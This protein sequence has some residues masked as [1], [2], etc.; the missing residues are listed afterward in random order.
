MSHLQ[1][2]LDLLSIED[3]L[4]I[5]ES[6]YSAGAD[7]LEVGTPL[8]KNHGMLAV[9]R[10]KQS[11]PQATVVA[12]LKTADTGDLEVEIAAK[13]GAGV[14][15]V[16]AL[17]DD[18]TIKKAVSQARAHGVKIMAD[19]MEVKDKLSRAR[20][21]QDLG[22]D[23]LLLHTPIDLQK[24]KEEKVDSSLQEL[25][26]IK[27][28]VS[29]P[30]AAAGGVTPESARLLRKE[31]VEIFVVGSSITRARDIGKRVKEFSEVLGVERPAEEK[32]V[33]TWEEIVEGFE[34]LP[35]PFI[36]DAMRRFGAMRSLRPLLRGKRIAGRAFT[37]KTL[38]G[39]WGKVVKAIDRAREGEILVVDAQ[40][41]EIGVWGGLATQSAIAR[42]IKGAVIDGAARDRDDIVEQDFPVWSRYITPHAG[43]P[44]GHGWLQVPV[45]CAGQV[46]EPG[47]II[48]AD[49]VGVVVV[50]R[51]EAQ[52]VLAK[53]REVE[54]KEGRYREGIMEGKSL[55]E[56]F[57]L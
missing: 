55:G 53:A 42:G 15:I 47:D 48:V 19:L 16:L 43:E 3:A 11:F 46:V 2:A 57:G 18:F 6:C 23:Y 36:T 31:G 51:E 24:V 26:R 28:Q 27:S 29:L 45:A 44:H 12:D 54:K 9:R 41:A 37:V 14:V 13:N 33:L 8:I 50:P 34:A 17:A 39:D 35:T 49:E 40:G 52:E 1:V 5:G 21:L 4:T 25:K 38:P 30:L 32:E 7:W 56:L 10:V 22:V 20:E